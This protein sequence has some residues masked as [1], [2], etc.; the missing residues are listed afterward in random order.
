MVL[1]QKAL[2]YH[3]KEQKLVVTITKFRYPFT[4]FGHSYL[5]RTAL[6][7]PQSLVKSL[8]TSSTSWLAILQV[9]CS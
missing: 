3:V 2:A 8:L 1:I 4:I 5:Q 7:Q 9:L 6:G